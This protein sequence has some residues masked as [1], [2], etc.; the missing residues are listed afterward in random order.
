M[1]GLRSHIKNSKE[2]FIRYPNTSNSV[3]KTRLRLVFSTHF[4]W[5]ITWRYCRCCCPLRFCLWE[6]L[7]CRLFLFL[8][9]FVKVKKMWKFVDQ[10]RF[11]FIPWKQM[12]SHLG[13]NVR[14]KHNNATGNAMLTL[15]AFQKKMVWEESRFSFKRKLWWKNLMK[16]KLALSQC[17]TRRNCESNCKLA[18]LVLSDNFKVQGLGELPLFR[19][20]V[21]ENVRLKSVSGIR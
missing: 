5:Y 12:P 6:W 10:T 9:S 7:W 18:Y 3:K 17:Y 20:F 1:N 14:R 2:C 21:V 4:S 13:S 15:R 8:C 19:T 16:L 11:A